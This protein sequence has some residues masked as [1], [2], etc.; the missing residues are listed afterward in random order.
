MAAIGESNEVVAEKDTVA[1]EHEAMHLQMAEMKEKITNLV[2]L[3]KTLEE[4]V[5]LAVLRIDRYENLLQDE[6]DKVKA[7][8]AKVENLEGNN[9]R[10]RHE[11]NDN[12]FDA[13]MVDTAPY[14]HD[15][16]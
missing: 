4:K 7:L 3:N 8:Q 15:F 9:A 11:G 10:L 14:Q 5:E 16:I 2:K 1:S 13:L 12:A 6:K